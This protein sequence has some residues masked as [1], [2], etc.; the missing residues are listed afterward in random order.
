MERGSD[1]HGSRVDDQLKKETEPLERSLAESHVEPERE[2]E[3]PDEEETSGTGH[4]ISGTGSSAE[5]YPWKDH[6][7]QGGASHPKPRTEDESGA[8]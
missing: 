4:R 8:P 1:K 7:E 2:R 5:E 3:S 6:G